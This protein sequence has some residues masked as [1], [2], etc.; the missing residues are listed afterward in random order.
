[1]GISLSSGI[2]D[3]EVGGGC[4]AKKNV[5]AS[6]IV[7]KDWV[8]RDIGDL[9]PEAGLRDIS[10]VDPVDKEST[11]GWVEKAQDEVGESGLA[12]TA[13]AD[14]GNY[15]SGFDGDFNMF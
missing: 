3:G 15:L 13:G 14:Q 7:E 10:N 1:M 12:S 5:V 4:F 2:F 8:L 11:F 6:G 9:I